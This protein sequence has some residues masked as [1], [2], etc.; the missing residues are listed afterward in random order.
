MDEGR[1]LSVK[2]RQSSESA[3]TRRRS[4]ELDTQLA[5]T[6]RITAPGNT[7]RGFAAAQK[8]TARE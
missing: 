7:L 2:P 5:G 1:E 8:R 3:V 4:A 6:T